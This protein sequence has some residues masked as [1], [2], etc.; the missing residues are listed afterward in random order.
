ME[1]YWIEKL[2]Q[3]LTQ[4]KVYTDETR[5][6]DMWDENVLGNT[7]DGGDIFEFGVSV[8]KTIAYFQRNFRETPIYGFDSFEGLPED[9]D[10]N[11]YV[12]EKGSFS[13]QGIPP[14]LPGITFVKGMFEDTVEHWFKNYTGYAKIIHID[15]DL[16]SSTKV[17]LD[18]IKPI[19]RVG[20]L[21]LFDELTTHPDHRAYVHMRQHEYK[22]F[23]EF[24]ETNP[25]FDYQV[26]ARTE[27]PQ[28]ALKVVSV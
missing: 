26:L 3:Q 6:I 14:D 22:A 11:G 4:V 1:N 25:S 17:V 28:V 16:Y 15:C 2:E 13:T 24:L 27:G 19:L 7:I 20:T 8:G 10:L 12:L 18:N 5:R 9:W 23:K 21:L